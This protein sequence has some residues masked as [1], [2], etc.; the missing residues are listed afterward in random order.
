LQHKHTCR[1]LVH[2]SKY[3]LA[4]PGALLGMGHSTVDRSRLRL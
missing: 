3:S 2:Q 1:T 4:L